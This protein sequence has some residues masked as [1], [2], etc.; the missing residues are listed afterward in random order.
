MLEWIN[1]NEKPKSFNKNR[2]QNK[3]KD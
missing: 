3:M 1:S 2:D